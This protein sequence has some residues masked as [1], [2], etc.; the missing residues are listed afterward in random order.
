MNI[1]AASVGAT[2]AVAMPL[3]VAL[4]ADL[5]LQARA[6]Y[7]Y[8]SMLGRDGN[9][10][11]I[12]RDRVAAATGLSR[13]P[14]LDNMKQLLT[15]GY[16]VKLKDNT[17]SR[18]TS[19]FYLLPNWPTKYADAPH[20]ALTYIEQKAVEGRDIYAPGICMIPE[21]LYAQPT[22]P[23]VA[24]G[25][26]IVMLGIAAANGSNIVQMSDIAEFTGLS[27]KTRG[28]S[29]VRAENSLRSRIRLL[30][31][32]NCLRQSLNPRKSRKRQ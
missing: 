24:K 19:P 9:P 21:T 10:F 18:F 32:R 29:S 14:F 22:V 31:T 25:F 13:D 7:G 8:L 20:R 26:Y 2:T 16:I 6:I 28:A 12:E 5:S 27:S 17:T 1:N 15:A 30:Q 11:G 3:V 4:D 23:G